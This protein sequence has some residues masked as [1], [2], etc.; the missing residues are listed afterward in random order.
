[1][2]SKTPKNEINSKRLLLMEITDGKV[3]LK[4]IEY[5]PI[6]ALESNLKLG[7]KVIFSAKLVC[8]LPLLITNN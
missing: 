3:N 6:P 7:S 2:H 1:M 8:I 4:A 5:K